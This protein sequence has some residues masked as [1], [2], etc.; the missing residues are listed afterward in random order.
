MSMKHQL[1]RLWLLTPF[2]LSRRID[3]LEW[4]LYNRR[5]AAVE[6]IAD[7]LVG[8]QLEGDYCE[9]G[10]FRGDTFGYAVKTCSRSERLA[11]MRFFAF[12]SF[13]GL[14]AP[15]GIDIISGFSSGFVP[16]EFACS[17]ENFTRNLVR[18]RVPL[19]RVRIVKGWFDKSLND[20]M[21]NR[22]KLSK[23]SVAWIDGDL[24][25]SCVPILNFLTSRISVGA[26]IAFDDWRVFRNL[27]DR[28]EQ[29][30]CAEWLTRN[31]QIEL[32]ELFSFGQHGIA[33]TVSRC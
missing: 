9:F 27:P 6:E 25:E 29:R 12:D 7:Y 2:G 18:N 28:G 30:A 33:F 24:Y 17:E 21:A 26:L 31:P 13:E 4:R 16:G 15:K 8:A 19:D 10:V 22:E 5:W 23:V 14:P 1:K 20:E 3:E 11:N 32:R